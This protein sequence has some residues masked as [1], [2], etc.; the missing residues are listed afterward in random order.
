MLVLINK[1]IK[2]SLDLRALGDSEIIF[3]REDDYY[4]KRRAERWAGWSK[5]KG[6]LLLI[7]E[8]EKEDLDRVP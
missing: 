6:T 2:D 5:W 7:N 4:T 3:G 8:E 1:E